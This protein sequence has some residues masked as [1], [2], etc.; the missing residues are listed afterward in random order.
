MLFSGLMV[1]G[2][3]AP[4]DERMGV[5]GLVVGCFQLELLLWSNPA[6]APSTSRRRKL[7]V[8]LISM[9]SPL[10]DMSWDRTSSS[11]VRLLTEAVSKLSSPSS[12]VRMPNR[13][14]LPVPGVC[15]ERKIPTLFGCGVYNP[16][17]YMVG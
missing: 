14:L 15:G 6:S 4:E 13:T 17:L 1:S 7:S 9:E 5:R 12:Y 10:M 3:S 2:A 8:K 11:S 16:P